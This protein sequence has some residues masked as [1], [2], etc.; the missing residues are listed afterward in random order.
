MLAAL[1][2]NFL[3]AALMLWIPFRDDSAMRAPE[4]TDSRRR[5]RWFPGPSRPDR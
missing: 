5:R 2:S 4:G 3:I 1:L